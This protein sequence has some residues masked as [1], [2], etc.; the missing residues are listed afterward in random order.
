MVQLDAHLTDDQE[1][2]GSPTAG[3]IMKYFYGHSLPSADSRKAFVSVWRKK[4]HNTGLPL[5]VLNL[6]SKSVVR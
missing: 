6:S 2:A 1:V 5:R 3:L 4:V